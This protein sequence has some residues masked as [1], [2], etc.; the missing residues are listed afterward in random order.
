MDLS[1][2]EEKC[3]TLEAATQQWLSL[4]RDMEISGESSHPRYET[5]FRGYVEAKQQEKRA[6]LELFN[7][8]QGLVD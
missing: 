8:Q 7:A 4:L 2:L 6:N 1:Q 5:Y 3:R